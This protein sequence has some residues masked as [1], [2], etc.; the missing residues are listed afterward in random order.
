[1]TGGQ[2][3]AGRDERAGDR[4]TASPPR[5]CGGSSIT[6]EDPARYDG[7]ALPA[8]AEVRDRRELL[9]TQRELAQVEGVTV[10]LHDQAC[11]AELRRDAQARPRARP[12]ASVS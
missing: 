11:A 4:R 8:I 12:A 6:T 2:D 3:V 9:A 10:L 7:V 5:A 1:M